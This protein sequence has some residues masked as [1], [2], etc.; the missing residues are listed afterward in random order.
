[1]DSNEEGS[2]EGMAALM[3]KQVDAIYAKASMKNVRVDSLQEAA[4]H[5]RQSGDAIARGDI[6]H[7]PS[8]KESPISTEVP[9]ARP[10]ALAVGPA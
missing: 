3:A 10:T 2:W 9:S 4:H 8:P 5:L 1:M 6:S 7:A